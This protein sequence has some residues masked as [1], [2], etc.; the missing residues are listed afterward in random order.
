[1]KLVNFGWWSGEYGLG[2]ICLCSLLIVSVE[3]LIVKQFVF[4]LLLFFVSN[5]LLKE[6][7]VLILFLP[8]WVQRSGLLW[9]RLLVLED[10][11][12]VE[13]W[14]LE[15]RLIVHRRILHVLWVLGKVDR[16]LLLLVM[17]CCIGG[18]LILKDLID[19]R[20]RGLV[21]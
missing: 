15:G 16:S 5:L 1:M 14:R 11:R 17:R 13:C 2:S 3:V 12:S 4:P 9:Q 6:A 19:F 21:L 7:A 10:R 18:L 20:Q 8:L